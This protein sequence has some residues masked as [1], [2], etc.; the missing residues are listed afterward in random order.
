MAAGD[1]DF[2]INDADKVSTEWMTKARRAYKERDDAVKALQDQLKDAKRGESPEQRA[3]R[4]DARADAWQARA[5]TIGSVGAGAGATVALLQSAQLRRNSKQYVRVAHQAQ[6]IMQKTA[7]SPIVGTPNADQL[8]GKI[9]AAKKSTSTKA[10]HAGGAVIALTGIAEIAYAH[11]FASAES[12]EMW[13]GMGRNT[14]AASGGFEAGNI[15]TSTI[16]KPKTPSIATSSIVASQTR[17]KREARA[18]RAHGVGTRLPGFD[19]VL[20][21]VP[22]KDL[23]GAMKPSLASDRQA[24]MV[25]HQSDLAAQRAMSE[26][27]LAS[28]RAATKAA[29]DAKAARVE[30]L[31]HRLQRLDNR[32]RPINRVKSTLDKGTRALVGGTKKT[33]RAIA[34]VGSLTLAGTKSAGSATRDALMLTGQK[35][36][37]LTAPM[38]TAVATRSRTIAANPKVRIAGKAGLALGLLALGGRGLMIAAA[39]NPQV[40]RNLSLIAKKAARTKMLR[41]VLSFGR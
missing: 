37:S 38:R 11:T 19:A 28:E 14:L 13:E 23:V 1:K 3:K 39:K 36:A 22:K 26:K 29:F 24:L 34:T 18:M 16:T 25:A 40:V 2:N 21:D 33:G 30:R 32:R 27:A 9:K 6:R 15:L 7:S 31:H 8:R 5:L 10:M 41:G 4:N 20:A 35:T 12:K 17:L